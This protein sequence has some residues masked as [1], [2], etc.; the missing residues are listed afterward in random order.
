[1]FSRTLI[2]TPHFDDETIG[3]GG[4][5]ASLAQNKDSKL[6]I[7][8]IATNTDTHNYSAGRVVTNTERY[9]ECIEAIKALGVTDPYEVVNQLEG[10]EDGRLDL[11]DRK[12]LVTAI[13]TVIREFRPTAVLFPYSSHHQ[14][15]QAVYQASIAALRPTLSTNF[16]K[17]KAAY[18]YPYI[19]TS[20][21]SS[22]RSDS[23]IYY[24]LTPECMKKKEDALR[25]YKSQL[26]RDPKDI[27]S[28]DSI[29]ML[30]KIRGTEIGYDY[31]EAFYPLSVVI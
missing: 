19:T 29:M 9:A 14:D 15:H 6:K 5:I 20:W 23:K 22:M 3:C 18:E 28:V 16:I 2:I 4:L 25:E 12:S 30:A 13:D 1:M 11:A 27:L 10:Y 7:L 17:L 24:T 8:V 31:A 26:D 21:N